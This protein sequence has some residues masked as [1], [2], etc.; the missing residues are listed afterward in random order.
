M[1]RKALLENVWVQGTLDE[2]G[3]PN[4]VVPLGLF[5]EGNDDI[6][7]VGCNLIEHPGVYRFHEVLRDI[8]AKAE[9]Q[10][11]LVEVSEV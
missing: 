5:F 11:V 6:G 9:V 2:W 8:E 10:A 4:P 3:A 7:S 1:T